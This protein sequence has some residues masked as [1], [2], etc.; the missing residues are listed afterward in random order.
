MLFS[1]NPP[2]IGSNRATYLRGELMS[3]KW[4]GIEGA[5]NRAT[6]LRG[7]LMSWKWA[8]IEGANNRATSQRGELMSKPVGRQCG[9]E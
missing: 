3:W 8:G 9:S 2:K 5:N 4:A 1:S 7:E 6:Y